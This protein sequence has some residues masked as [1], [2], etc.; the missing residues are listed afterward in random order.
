[1]LLYLPILDVYTYVRCTM[2]QRIAKI[3][4]SNIMYCTLYIVLHVVLIVFLY[5]LYCNY[6]VFQTNRLDMCFVLWLTHI[7]IFNFKSVLIS[8][9][10]NHAALKITFIVNVKLIYNV[11]SVVKLYSFEKKNLKIYHRLYKD[12]EERQICHSSH[13]GNLVL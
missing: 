5:L 9:L 6:L 4:Y 1:M 7:S 11:H 13:Y 8:L 12:V 2:R 3:I 10:I